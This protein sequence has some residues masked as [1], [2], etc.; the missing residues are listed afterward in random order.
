MLHTLNEVLLHHETDRFCTLA[1]ARLRRNASGWNVT[2]SCGGH[3]L[4]LLVGPDGPPLTVGQPGSLVGIFTAPRFHD[5]E[6]ELKP[7]QAI[8]AYTDGVTETRGTGGELFGEGRLARSLNPG[9]ASAAALVQ[10]LLDEVV[11]FQTG[12]PNDDV[13]VVVVARPDPT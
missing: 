13:A 8:V 3:P 2:V 1:L 6:I 11:R 10:G 12:N 5:T 9:F 7:G 4:P